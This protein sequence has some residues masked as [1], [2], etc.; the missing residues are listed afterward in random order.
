VKKEGSPLTEEDL[1][2]HC[3]DNLA[4]YKVPALVEFRDELPKSAVGKLL[5]RVLA[6]EEREKAGLAPGEG[7]G[8]EGR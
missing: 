3:K 7:K 4:P 5:K 6:E 8:V 2:A 1:I